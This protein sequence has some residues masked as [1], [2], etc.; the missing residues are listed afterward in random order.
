MRR[1]LLS[2][3]EILA[4]LARLPEWTRDSG[5]ISRTYSFADFAQAMEF[6]NQ[7]AETAES[8][9]HHPDI[10]IRYGKVTLALTTH[11]AHGL[12]LND[13]N[14]AAACDGFAEGITP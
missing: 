9:D 6:V 5:M 11:D 7:V 3:D 4:H 10:D 8:V 1:P 14:L 12:T 13:V 2:E